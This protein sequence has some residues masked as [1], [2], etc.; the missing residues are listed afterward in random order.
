MVRIQGVGEDIVSGVSSIMKCCK[1][2][3]GVRGDVDNIS[4]RVFDHASRI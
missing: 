3:E 1:E 2:L 4:Q